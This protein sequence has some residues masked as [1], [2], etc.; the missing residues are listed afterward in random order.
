LSEAL[1]GVLSGGPDSLL[2][3]YSAARRPIARDVVAM[4][5]RLTRLATLPRIARPLR[6][7]VFSVVGWLPAANRALAWRLS[8]LVYR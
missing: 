3:D 8:G 5:D 2:D 6:N 7:L 4:T 1:A